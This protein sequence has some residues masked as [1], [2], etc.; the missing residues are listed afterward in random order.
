MFFLCAAIQIPTDFN[1]R[2]HNPAGWFGP[3]TKSGGESGYSRLITN[4]QELDDLLSTKR[5]FPEVLVIPDFLVNKGNLTKIEKQYDPIKFLHGVMVYSS[6]TSESS[7]ASAFPNK[8]QSPYSDDYI[9]NPYG[10]GEQYDKYSFVL[11]YPPNKVMQQLLEKIKADK[12]KS[13]FY[14]DFSMLSRG[15]LKYCLSHTYDYN[16]QCQPVGGLSLIGGFNNQIGGKAV[17]LVSQMDAFGIAPYGQVGA[18]YS[19]SGFVASLAALESLKNLD[20]KSAKRPLHFGFFD[21]EEI[22]NLGSSRFL[23]EIK[24]FTCEEYSEG[25]SYCVRPKRYDFFFQNISYDDFSTVLE[26]KSVGLFEDEGK[27]FAHTQKSDNEK[28]FVQNLQN[29]FNNPLKITSADS[30]TPGVPPSTT[31]SFV[32]QIPNIEHVVFAGHDKTYVNKVIGTPSDDKYDVDYVTKAATTVARSLAFLC[33]QDKSI[34]EGIEANKTLVEGIMQGFVDAPNSSD[35]FHELF[36]NASLA[37]DHVSLYSGV[38]NGY[39]TSF[40]HMIVVNMLKDVIRTEFDE[41]NKCTVDSNCTEA[42]GQDAFCSR[43]KYCEKSLIRSFPAYS[44]AFEVNKDDDFYIA[45]NNSEYEAMAEARWASPDIKY[46]LLPTV[47][48]GRL[49]ISIG[50][51]FTTILAY[52]S[53]TRWN[54]LILKLKK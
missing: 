12:Q 5:S 11:F 20:W 37:T 39:S 15:N 38:Y 16:A 2:I 33:F 1:F 18:D 52:I 27:I 29:S 46:V 21:A 14:I 40:K 19:I 34:A 9:W 44:L 8:A 22:G 35:Y 48:S 42:Y 45:R 36:P 24:N 23:Y 32:K 6:N 31:S 28:I 41:S 47:M 51:V 3:A 54:S 10:N 4:E 13:G 17:W 49:L 25:K 53:L 26:V 43:Q 7:T 50:L 30:S